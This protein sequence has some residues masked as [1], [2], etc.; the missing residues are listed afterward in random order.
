MMVEVYMNKYFRLILYEAWVQS[1]SEKNLFMN[2]Q[3]KKTKKRQS[4]RQKNNEKE[5]IKEKKNTFN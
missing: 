4:L 3:K 5:A 1:S 2:E